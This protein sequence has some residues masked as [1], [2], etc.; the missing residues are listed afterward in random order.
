MNNDDLIADNVSL[1]IFNTSVDQAGKLLFAIQTEEE[2]L[3]LVV[4]IYSPMT[5]WT[6]KDSFPLIVG[7]PFD[8]MPIKDPAF[9]FSTIDGTCPWNSAS[10]S[11]TA[12]TG[13]PKQTLIGSIVPPEVAKP[14]IE[15]LKQGSFPTG[16]I[17]LIGTLDF[18]KYDSDS[19]LYPTM[20][21]YCSLYKGKVSLPS[22]PLKAADPRIALIIP[23][24][25]SD[26]KKDI[27]NYSHEG[28]QIPILSVQVDLSVEDS[29]KDITYVLSAWLKPYE[30]PYYQFSL[31]WKKDA[32]LLSPGAVLGLF[33]NE[34]GDYFEGVP[35]P[36]RQ[37]MTDI[38]LLGFGVE[39]VIDSNKIISVTAIIGSTEDINFSLIPQQ[40]TNDL[41][42]KL[43]NFYL[44]WSVL[45]PNDLDARQQIFLFKTQLD[46]K[47]K[48]SDLPFTVEFD[49]DMQFW[50]K[51]EG[52]LVINDLLET[53]RS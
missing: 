21:I 19:V 30:T 12:V 25:S 38:G 23:P 27:E 45:S 39:G 8:E 7:W 15:L 44:T 14:I 34:V 10:G 3:T 28:D 26:E 46:L 4:Q 17:D 51:T 13:G 24:P 2:N 50:A 11:Q 18:E 6:W 16:D 52:E 9:V 49:S 42:F 53:I 33:P 22:L 36:L 43:K 20:E 31:D 29:K 41:D 5:N 37:F 48:S 1:S 47:I 40:L 32:G 35:T